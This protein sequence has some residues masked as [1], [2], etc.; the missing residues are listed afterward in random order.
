MN[1]E[2]TGNQLLNQHW[3]IDLDWYRANGCSFTTLTQDY[4]CPRCRKKLKKETKPEDIIKSLST[5][6]SRKEEFI[7]PDLPVM[8]GVFKYFLASGNKPVELDTLSQELSDRRGTI[9][10]TSPTILHRLLMNDRY[11]G[12]RP[13]A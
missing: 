8:T 6:C 4:L 7:Q 1:S 3:N 2:Q 5:C 10:G 9:A 12:L 13:S 11:Y